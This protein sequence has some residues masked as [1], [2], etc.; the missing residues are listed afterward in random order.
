MKELLTPDLYQ[1]WLDIEASLSRLRS[2][3][4]APDLEA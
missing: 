3:S 2:V 4:Q 1:A